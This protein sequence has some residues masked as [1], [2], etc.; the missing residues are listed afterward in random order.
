MEALCS[1]IRWTVHL[2]NPPVIDHFDTGFLGFSLSSNKYRG[3]SKLLL[4]VSHASF[5]T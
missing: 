4:H 1:F 5:R 2:E 3:A